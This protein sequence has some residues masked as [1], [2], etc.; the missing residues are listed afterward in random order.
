MR[1]LRYNVPEKNENP[2]NKQTSLFEHCLKIDRKGNDLAPGRCGL[3]YLLIYG[4]TD[5]QR[6]GIRWLFGL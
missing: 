1:S 2:K 5:F 3:I 4:F 6:N